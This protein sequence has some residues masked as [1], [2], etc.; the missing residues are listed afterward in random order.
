MCMNWETVILVV[1]ANL[2]QT[3]IVIW[4]TA[5]YA[6]KRTAPAIGEYLSSPDCQ[7]HVEGFMERIAQSPKAQRIAGKIAVSAGTQAWEGLT[8][9]RIEAV[10]DAVANSEKAKA[11]AF[12]VSNNAATLAWKKITGY[13]GGK[14]KGLEYAKRE[15]IDP[16]GKI[17]AIELVAEQMGLG[18]LKDNPWVRSQIAEKIIAQSQ[19]AGALPANGTNGT[20]SVPSWM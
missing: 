2:V 15:A 7:E 5:R 6:A 12:A 9:D 19:A 16:D 8:P 3:P 4:L 10:M 1:V 11:M 14:T 18:K 17:E 13:V 20:N